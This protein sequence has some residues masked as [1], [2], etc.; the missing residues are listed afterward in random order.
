ME[1]PEPESFALSATAFSLCYTG[2]VNA[3]RMTNVSAFAAPFVDPEE[4]E[5]EAAPGGPSP[6]PVRP[7]DGKEAFL[8]QVAALSAAARHRQHSEG[9]KALTFAGYGVVALMLSSLHLPGSWTWWLYFVSVFWFVRSCGAAVE[10]N[11]ARIQSTLSP[12]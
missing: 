3:R 10:W 8:A 6:R 9:R 12:F 7:K 11:I 5:Y 2:G 4:E 1:L